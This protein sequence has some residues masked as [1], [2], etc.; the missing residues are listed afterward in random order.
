MVGEVVL[1]VVA[2]GGK[3][4]HLWLAVTFVL[5]VVSRYRRGEC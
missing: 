3:R 1:V 5:I 4:R 2:I